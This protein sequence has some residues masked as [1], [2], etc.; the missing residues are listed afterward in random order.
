M[1]NKEK[2][3]ETFGFDL[4]YEN[5]LC[6]MLICTNCPFAHNDDCLERAGVFWEQEYEEVER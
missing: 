1:K 3:K 5:G 2:F 4:D 6:N